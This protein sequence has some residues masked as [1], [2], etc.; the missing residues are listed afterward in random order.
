VNLNFYVNARLAHQQDIAVLNDFR[1]WSDVMWKEFDQIGNCPNEG[2][3]VT[4][5]L[6]GAIL[7][8]RV[9]YVLP[10]RMSFICMTP[11]GHHTLVS[12]DQI[13]EEEVKGES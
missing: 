6:H 3:T 8:A 5:A 4:V 12:V 1:P 10:H 7:P 11:L 13:V 9:V 2:D